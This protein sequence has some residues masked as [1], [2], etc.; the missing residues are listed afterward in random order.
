MMQAVILSAVAVS[1]LAQST[2]RA[3]RAVMVRQARAA[4]QVRTWEKSV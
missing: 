3:K 4:K 1:M 2:R